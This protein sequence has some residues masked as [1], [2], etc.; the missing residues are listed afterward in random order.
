MAKKYYAQK[1]VLGF[2]LPCTLVSE[3]EA[4]NIESLIEVNTEP[5]L[6]PEGKEFAVHPLNHKFYIRKDENGNVIPNS[7]TAS[8]LEDNRPNTIEVKIIK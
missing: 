2:P 7:L 5:A 3:D 4:T 6:L 1:D 8:A